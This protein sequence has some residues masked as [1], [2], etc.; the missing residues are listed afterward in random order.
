MKT[1]NEDILGEG[2]YFFGGS[3]GTI[4]DHLLYNYK[5]NNT[6]LKAKYSVTKSSKLNIP[7]VLDVVIA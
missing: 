1:I 5:E 3:Y 7:K 4:P 6:S 2:I